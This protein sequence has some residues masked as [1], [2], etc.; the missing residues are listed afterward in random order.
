MTASQYASDAKIQEATTAIGA[1]YVGTTEM[2]LL[3]QILVAV[4]TSSGGGGGGSA[5]WGSITGTLSAQTDLQSALNA[6]AN[7][8]GGNTFVGTQVIPTLE[9]PGSISGIATLQAPPV[10][11]TPTITL[12]SVTSTLATL[13]ANGFSGAQ[14]I[15]VGTVTASAS[16]LTVTQTRNNAAVTFE[17]ISLDITDT[18]SATDSRWLRLTRNATDWFAIQKSAFN[19]PVVQMRR[20]GDSNSSAV[21]MRGGVDQL[22]FGFG[23]HTSQERISFASNFSA[24]ALAN[25]WKLGFSSSAALGG[26]SSQVDTFLMRGGAAATLQMGE[27]SATPS[28]QTLKGPNGSGTNIAA[29]RVNLAPGQSTG[30]ATPAILALQGTA[31]GSSGTT[32]QTLVDVLT[33]DSAT[34]ITIT[35]GVTVYTSSTGVTFGENA[36]AALAFFGASPVNQGTPSISGT[37]TNAGSGSPILDD[38]TVTGGLGSTAY[39]VADVVLILKQLGF[40]AQ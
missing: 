31:A 27:T 38:T 2:T 26:G 6:K 21:Y 24:I 3:Q 17:G 36:S 8:S 40:I 13:G 34:K 7:L 28:T 29:G 12:P 14:T 33:V 37:I 35:G 11:G 25:N 16:P 5:S 39:S 30:N 9:I 10:A 15:A 18:A 22:N 20:T 1:S 4:A 23:A 32:A 19:D